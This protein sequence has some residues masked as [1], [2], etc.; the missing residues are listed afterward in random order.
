M[1]GWGVHHDYRDSCRYSGTL[2][3]VFRDT[4]L[5]S[6]KADGRELGIYGRAH[7]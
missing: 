3:A 6:Q 7:I 4:A 1:Y 2:D 5:P